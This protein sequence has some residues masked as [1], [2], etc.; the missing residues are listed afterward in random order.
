MNQFDHGKGVDKLGIDGPQQQ[1]YKQQHKCLSL[2]FENNM[3]ELISKY[4]S[5]RVVDMHDWPDAK[6]ELI[7]LV[8]ELK[9]DIECQGKTKKMERYLFS[10]PD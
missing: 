1:H 7:E 8:L 2:D 9:K 10:C 4:N 3:D 5:T 6:M